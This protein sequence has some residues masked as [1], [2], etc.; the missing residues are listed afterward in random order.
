MLNV[1][2]CLV[3]LCNQ[4]QNPLALKNPLA[5]Y[6]PGIP[7]RGAGTIL[8]QPDLSGYDARQMKFT[9]AKVKQKQDEDKK[10]L[11][12]FEKLA[13]IK[14]TYSHIIHDEADKG[15]EE[16][17]KWALGVISKGN[18]KISP[19]D[20]Q[21][22]IIKKRNLENTFAQSLRAESDYEKAQTII[23]SDYAKGKYDASALEEMRVKIEDE[24]KKP[25]K[26]QNIF[27]IINAQPQFDLSE[28][29]KKVIIPNIESRATKDGKINTIQQDPTGVKYAKGERVKVVPS[30]IARDEYRKAYYNNN[31][32]KK[33]I[34]DAFNTRFANSNG[35]GFDVVYNEITQDVNGNVKATYNQV[36]K[37]TNINDYI[38]YALAQGKI[39]K[40]PTINMAGGANIGVTVNQ[41]QQHQGV[42]PYQ[43]YT[44]EF[45]LP[46]GNKASGSYPAIKSTTN[47]F[48]KD[49]ATTTP[50][51][52]TNNAFSFSGG[53]V[54]S[55]QNYLVDNAAGDL[56]P[57]TTK[58]VSYKGVLIPAGTPIGN[59]GR[60]NAEEFINDPALRGNWKWTGYYN[61]TAKDQNTGDVITG[62]YEKVTDAPTL[63]DYFKGKV[64]YKGTDYNWVDYMRIWENDVNA[65]W[66]NTGNT[67]PS[68][69]GAGSKPQQNNNTGGAPRP[70]KPKK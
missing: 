56:I 24:I 31:L 18:G 47:I 21:E 44:Y 39:E 68:Y 41:Q 65:E 20:M 67:S 5:Y 66:G 58:A 63:A 14:G 36:K 9:D 60:I 53:Q 17:D 15:M 13:Q 51:Q 19:Y 28:Y 7:G 38:D 55:R 52:F 46:S 45:T 64:S 6:T 16:F 42:T 23:T 37:I 12:E 49:P 50:Y 54:K 26:E 48:A 29:E 3:S 8:K 40:I 34:N 32:V 4:K 61:V 11:D 27:S 35:Q 2:I 22:A 10:A 30:N 59:T 1:V 69:S 43:N 57:V 70:P 62:V 25:L 33:Q